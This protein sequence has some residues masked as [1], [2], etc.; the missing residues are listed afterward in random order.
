[1]Q[2]YNT[3]SINDLIADTQTVDV[4]LYNAINLISQR[5]HCFDISY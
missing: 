3:V 4:G 2:Q 5:P 1:M